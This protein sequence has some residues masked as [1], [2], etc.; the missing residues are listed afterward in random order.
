MPNSKS[1][2]KPHTKSKSAPK[3]AAKSK[4]VVVLVGT[5]KGGFIFRS[6]LRR[7]TWAIEGPLFPGMQVHH[8][9][10]DHR[11]PRKIMYAATNSDW[12]GADLQRTLDGGKTW[13]ASKG[14]V[15]YEPDSDLS[16]KRVWHI[17]PGRENESGVV[18]C[19]VD[20]A[21]LF[22]SED[23]GESWSEV[24]GLNRHST[25]SKWTPGAG[26]MIAHTILLDPHS[27]QRMYV[28][29][30][31]AG[32]FRSDDGGITWTPRNQG[33]RAD[34]LP[35]T[36]PELGQ[37]VHKLALAPG[38]PGL[39]YQQNHCGMY[40]SDSAG[41]SWTDISD[42]LP[43]R[44]GFPIAVHPR[45]PQSIW[46]L[47]LIGAEMRTVPNG[48]LAVHH[49]TN[50]G[51]TWQM[52]TRGLPTRDAYHTILRE[53]MSTDTCESAGVYFGAEGGQLYY[54]RDEGTRWQVLSGNLPPIISVEAAVL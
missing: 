21:G 15:R 42:G 47:P 27:P 28:A 18:Y 39:L 29:I 11:D 4:E 14:G 7:K 50:G 20:P 24:K 13:L 31:A 49:S 38:A 34:F 40:R 33:T 43:S 2:S 3:S 46:V 12:F 54:T 30:S 41:D 36:M 53:A 10:T 35:D 23:G 52:Q 16:V 37:C 19:G 17:R 5:R 45:D 6:D 26:G 9:I 8:F 22:R 51:K 32:V 48:T 44:F 25:R 1:K